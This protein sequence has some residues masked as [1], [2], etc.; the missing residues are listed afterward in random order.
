MNSQRGATRTLWTKKKPTAPCAPNRTA[1]H[2]ARACARPVPSFR[3]GLMSSPFIVERCALDPSGARSTCSPEPQETIAHGLRKPEESVKQRAG[4]PTNCPAS[5]PGPSTSIGRK[6]QQTTNIGRKGTTFHY[7]CAPYRH[8]LHQPHGSK[9]G[10]PQDPH[11]PD[12]STSRRHQT[13][14]CNYRIM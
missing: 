11:S 4:T 13:E 12:F 3:H 7:S 6:C 1:A 5:Q 8:V 10:L 9:R 2:G 14:L